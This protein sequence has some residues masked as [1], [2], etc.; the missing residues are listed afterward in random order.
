MAR[1]VHVSRVGGYRGPTQNRRGIPNKVNA[2]TRERIEESGD[3][4]GFLIKIMNGEA[5]PIL[6]ANGEVTGHD[7]PTIEHRVT[8]A[9]ELLKKI[10]PDLKSVEVSGGL[11][12]PGAAGQNSMFR[13]I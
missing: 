9:K 3:P 13:P 8:A 11:G 4:V 2:V 12:R 7:L 1:V 10:V 6:D 5:L